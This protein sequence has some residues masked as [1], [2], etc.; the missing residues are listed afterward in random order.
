MITQTI[1]AV[2]FKALLQAVFL[3]RVEN[4]S[5]LLAKS[6]LHNCYTLLVF[7]LFLPGF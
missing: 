6:R 7:S 2:H 1:C 4:I 5:S 3:V